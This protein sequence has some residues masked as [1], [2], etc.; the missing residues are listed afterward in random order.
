MKTIIITLAILF[1]TGSAYADTAT[2]L[3]GDGSV[4][5]WQIIRNGNN[6]QTNRSGR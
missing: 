3:R 1:F 4:E 2:I 6:I 5:N